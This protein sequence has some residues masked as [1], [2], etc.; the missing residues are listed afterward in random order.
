MNSSN[1]IGEIAG[2]ATSLFY[3]VNAIFITKASKQVGSTIS[4]RVRVAF[5]LIYLVII[6]LIFFKEPLPFHATSDRWVWLSLSGM[7]GLAFGD[8]FLFQSYLMVGPQIG[9]LLLSLSPI[10][11][12]LEAWIF[13]HESLT[14]LKILGILLTLAGIIWVVVAR[15]SNMTQTKKHMLAGVMYGILSAIFQATGFVFS[16]QGLAG[17]FSPFQANAIRMLA[18]FFILV[19]IML[20][21]KE[22]NQTIQTLRTNSG[23]LKLLAIAGFIGPVLGVSASLLSVQYAE[24]GVASTLTSL[25]PVFMLPLGYFFL[26]EEIHWTSVAGTILALLGV[27]ILFLT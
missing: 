8:A 22:S 3:A 5:A 10:V 7:I 6:N 25:S 19:L 4:N 20:L 16:K 21:Q 18:A 15:G 24:V 26:N 11:G 13:F 23:T 1:L 2:L 9:S 27:A 14:P 17:N 12:A